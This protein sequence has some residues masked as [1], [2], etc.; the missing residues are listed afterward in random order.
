MPR[1]WPDGKKRRRFGYVRKLPSGRYQA[2]FIGPSGLRQTAPGTFR[3]TTNADRWLSAAEADILRGAWLSGQD[4]EREATVREVA[5]HG[6]TV[7]RETTRGYYVMRCSCGRHQ[8]TMHKTPG[9]SNHFRN[10]VASMIRECSTQRE[11]E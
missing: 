5:R 9:L 1:W 7:A 2:S 3:T 10:K 8:T 6:W 11:G 4:A